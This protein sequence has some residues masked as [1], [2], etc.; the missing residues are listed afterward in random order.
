VLQI[1]GLRTLRTVAKA[2]EEIKG[3]TALGESASQWYGLLLANM[4]ARCRTVA[5]FPSVS[6]DNLPPELIRNEA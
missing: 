4:V 5:H 2:L 1:V 3:R 6:L